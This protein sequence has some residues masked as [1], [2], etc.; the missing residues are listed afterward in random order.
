MLSNKK[1]ATSLFWVCGTPMIHRTNFSQQIAVLLFFINPTCCLQFCSSCSCLI[2]QRL[3]EKTSPLLTPP[4]RPALKWL[5]AAATMAKRLVGVSKGPRVGR[6]I[7]ITMRNLCSNWV[8]TFRAPSKPCFFFSH[9]RCC[10]NFSTF[11]VSVLDSVPLINHGGTM[12]KQPSIGFVW[13]WDWSWI[14]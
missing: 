9:A 12:G 13:V 4:T 5:P 3:W 6:P 1:T 8:F 10:F 11:F 2:H 7:R 14:H